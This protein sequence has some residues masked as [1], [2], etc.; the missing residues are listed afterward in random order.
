MLCTTFPTLKMWQLDGFWQPLQQE[1]QQLQVTREV[2]QD[3]LLLFWVEILCKASSFMGTI[4]NQLVQH[5]NYTTFSVALVIQAFAEYFVEKKMFFQNK[6]LNYIQ[7]YPSN[8]Q[9]YQKFT[10]I[11]CPF[12]IVNSSSLGTSNLRFLHFFVVEIYFIFLLLR[13]IHF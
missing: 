3:C 5:R 10:N 7:K 13:C 4:G 6:H 1:V 2:P 11:Y 12:K 9:F 8:M